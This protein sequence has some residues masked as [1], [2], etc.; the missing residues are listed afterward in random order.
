[1][2]NG[3]EAEQIKEIFDLYL[4]KQSLQPV[5]EELGRR[6][7]NN[8]KRIK[9]KGKPIGDRPFDNATLYNHLTNFDLN[10]EDHPKR[11]CMRR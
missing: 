3:A 1:M 2:I 5:R 6:G 8:K 9:A 7:W 10:R 4:E 11:E